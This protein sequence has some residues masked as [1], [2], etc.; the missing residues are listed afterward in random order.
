M[1]VLNCRETGAVCYLLTVLLGVTSQAENQRAIFDRNLLV[2]AGAEQAMN[3]QNAAPGWGP[4]QEGFVAEPYGHTTTEWEWNLSGCA[5]C[6]KQYFRV[7]WEGSENSSRTISQTIDITPAAADVDAGR[8]QARLAGYLG[9]IRNTDTTG[10]LQAIFLS[11]TGQP[12]GGGGPVETAPFDS[13]KLPKAR[14]G[15]ASI[16]PFQAEGRVPAG[17]RKIRVSFV[18][19]PT[20]G[21]GAYYGFADQ[22][23]LQLFRPSGN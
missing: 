10:Y 1:R 9:T 14:E 3:D 17:A 11:A 6:G 18:V 12:V 19:R 5:G 7:F 23:S 21:S 22:L 16:V 4:A 15:D 2:N 8:V 13:K 20:G